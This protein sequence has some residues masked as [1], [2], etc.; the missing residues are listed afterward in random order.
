VVGDR[1]TKVGEGSRHTRKKGGKERKRESR[2]GTTFVCS[3]TGPSPLKGKK[4]RKGEAVSPRLKTTKKERNSQGSPTR[5][6][7]M[8]GKQK[9]DWF[10]S[11]VG[12]ASK[13][14]K[15]SSDPGKKN[16]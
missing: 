11:T 6:A 16:L 13:V 7:A 15:A 5:I 12:P 1:Q 2:G 8:K 3:R 4:T 9:G 14:L 10:T